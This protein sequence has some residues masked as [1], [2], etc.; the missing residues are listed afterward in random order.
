[1]KTIFEDKY[2]KIIDK[3]AGILS[4]DISPLICHRLDRDTSGL[5]IIAKGGRA[6]EKMQALFKKRRIK[7]KYLSLVSGRFE[8]KK[9]RVE[10]YIVRHKKNRN[11]RRFIQAPIFGVK[12]KHKRLAVS[13]Y[14]VKKEY[15]INLFKNQSQLSLN[16]LTLLKITLSTGRTHQ[17]RVQFSSIHHP[18]A[19][20]LL[21][22]GKLMKKINK[23]LHLKRQF[24]H[25]HKLR[26]IHPYAKK[27]IKIKSPLP[28]DLYGL[29][30]K[31]NGSK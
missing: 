17:I 7:K 18:V 3:K 2:Y 16:I 19:G 11:K 25:A 15:K 1:M 8:T 27:E 24:L 9:G 20:D 21:Y 13:T 29:L 28:R 4:T 10:G 31:L 22:G 6:K 12:E 26:F 5:L 23:H 14:K 30:Q